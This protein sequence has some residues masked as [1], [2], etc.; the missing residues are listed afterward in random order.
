MFK[1]KKG[2]LD[3]KVLLGVCRNQVMLG[4]F[5]SAK[6]FENYSEIMKRF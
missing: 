6:E 2:R 4:L 5:S 1:E 3:E